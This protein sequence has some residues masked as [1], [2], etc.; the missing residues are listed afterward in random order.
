MFHVRATTVSEGGHPAGPELKTCST[1]W[2]PSTMR[3]R[4]MACCWM[5]PA[6]A[7]ED[8]AGATAIASTA[9]QPLPLLGLRDRGS[10]A[11]RRSLPPAW[12]RYGPA[13]LTPW[14]QIACWSNMNPLVSKVHACERRWSAEFAALR[15]MGF[16][17]GLNE[18]FR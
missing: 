6:F 12:R 15:Q 11:L 1:K 16:A 7:P 13:V 8:K 2:A 18:K 10:R 3:W 4:A 9:Y 17:T 5:V 14:M